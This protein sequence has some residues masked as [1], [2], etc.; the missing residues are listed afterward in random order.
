[1]GTYHRLAKEPLNL[2]EQSVVNWWLYKGLLDSYLLEEQ[3]VILAHTDLK[4]KGY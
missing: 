2:E 4:H 3:T 1:M